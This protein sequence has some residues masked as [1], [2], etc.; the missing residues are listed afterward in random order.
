MTRIGKYDNYDKF[1]YL[2]STVEYDNSGVMTSIEIYSKS[3]D[4]RIKRTIYKGYN[5]NNSYIEEINIGYLKYKLQDGNIIEYI[6]YE[7]NG[8]NNDIKEKLQELSMNHKELKLKINQKEIEHKICKLRNIEFT[9]SKKL[10]YY[11]FKNEI[12]IIKQIYKD[13][14]V[15]YEMFIDENNLIRE[16]VDCQVVKCSLVNNTLINEYE[17]YY[18]YSLEIIKKYI[19]NLKSIKLQNKQVNIFENILEIKDV[20]L[21]RDG[22]DTKL[23]Y[24]IG[25]NQLY[26]TQIEYHYKKSYFNDETKNTLIYSM[27]IRDNNKYEFI[28]HPI[29]NCTLINGILHGKYIYNVGEFDPKNEKYRDQINKL[30][31]HEYKDYKNIFENLI[32]IKDI[33]F[34]KIKPCIIYNYINGHVEGLVKE[35]DYDIENNKLIEM[36]VEYNISNNKKEGVYKKYINNLLYREYTY[37]NDKKH[38]LMNYYEYNEKYHNNELV[39][40]VEYINGVAS[41]QCKQYTWYYEYVGNI[42]DNVIKNYN[43]QTRIDKY[44]TLTNIY[45]YSVE[46]KEDE[47]T[48]NNKNNQ[49]KSETKLT[50]NNNTI[51]NT[52]NNPYDGKIY[53]LTCNSK[54]INNKPSK[55][56]KK[57]EEKEKE[58]EKEEKEEIKDK[59]KDNK[60]KKDKLTNWFSWFSP[61]P[62]M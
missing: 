2:T 38:G 53:K 30:A 59:V 54:I 22:I 61:T 39:K 8:K 3:K 40:Q 31:M 19:E 43:E 57:E 13:G 1:G 50:T 62:Y 9:T 36:M 14:K 35:Y 41:L 5:Y 23:K 51:N 7:Y 16:N 28:T 37:V 18:V 48:I 60:I 26:L 17:D 52:I 29:V 11:K 58:K 21:T 24:D 33:K 27:D 25:D 15:I 6:E 44:L 12:P 55:K 56:E 42:L 47:L 49:I 45:D 20:N 34:M 46:H 10:F 4:P 32:Q